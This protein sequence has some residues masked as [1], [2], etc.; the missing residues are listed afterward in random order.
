MF[1][2]PDNEPPINFTNMLIEKIRDADEL[3]KREKAECKLPRDD[4]N[5]GWVI[6]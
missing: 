6:E 2:I 3:E 5:L 4:I 1:T